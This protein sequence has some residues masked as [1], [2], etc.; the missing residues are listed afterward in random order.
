MIINAKTSKYDTRETPYKQIISRNIRCRVPGHFLVGKGSVIDDFSYFSTKIEVGRFC[1]IAN[2]VSI[3]GGRKY[4]FTLGDYSS[5]SSGVRVWCSSDDF[6]CDMSVLAPA[7]IE[8]PG[9]S[10]NGDV[11]ISEL[12]IIGCNSVIMPDNDIPAGVAIGALSFVPA[13]F[14][15]EEWFLYAGI[16]IRPIR[17]R[18]KAKVLRQ[19]KYFLDQLSLSRKRQK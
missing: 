9:S 14:K 17:R 8:L 4:K 12:T 10:I 18:D 11:S 1:H 6:S 19:K 7:G 15:F 2:N 16:P 13:G 3:A 5:I